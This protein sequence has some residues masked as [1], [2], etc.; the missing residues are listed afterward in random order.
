M[1]EEQAALKAEMPEGTVDDS[2]DD[3]PMRGRAEG[4]PPAPTSNTL[5]DTSAD[6][7]AHA[8]QVAPHNLRSLW[9]TCSALNSGSNSGSS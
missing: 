4:S 2:S 1:Q 9:Y 3:K 6:A 8:E 7:A 5:F